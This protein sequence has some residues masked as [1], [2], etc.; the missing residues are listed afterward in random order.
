MNRSSFLFL[1]VLSP[2]FGFTQSANVPLNR[3][4][5]HLLER[6][7]ILNGHFSDQFHSEVKPYQRQRVG[8]FIDSLYDHS[9]LL[10]LSERDRFNL[11]YLANDSWEWTGSDSS[12]SQK[13]LLRYFYKKKPDLLHV[14]VPDFDLHLNPVI[15]FSGGKEQGSDITT[16]RNTRGLELRGAISR[17]LGFY[18][19]M[20]TTQAVN[21][22]YVRD[23]IQSNGVVPGEGFWKKF[24]DNGVDY[25]TAR[26]YIN[27]EVVKKYV[28]AEFGFDQTFIGSGH[29]SVIL[30]DF[31]PGYTYLKFNTKIW[32][33]NYTN[34][35]AQAFADQKYSATGSLDGTFPK[36]FLASHHLS[37]D[38]SRRLNIGVFES[39]VI[40]DSTE[41]FNAA[42][43]NPIIFY[44][45]LEHQGGSSENAM[46]GMDFKWIIGHSLSLYGQL[47]LDEFLLDEIKSGEGWWANKFGGQ[48]GGKY[49]N[50]AAIPN[51]DLQLEYNFAR[52]YLHAHEDIYTNYAHYRQPLGHTL[53]GN[54]TELVGIIRYQP[55]NR[56]F[57]TGQINIANYGDDT[58][59]SNWG[60][61]VMK[62]YNTREMEY[63]NKIGQGVATKLL[64]GQLMLSY[65]WKHN[66]FFDVSGIYRTLDSAQDANDTNTRYLKAA[67]RWNIARKIHDF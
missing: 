15:Y 21:P 51:L 31:S 55:L 30:S 27:F 45:A 1:L 66:L 56:L 61:N 11:V 18:S 60:K 14:E 50:V 9:D 8:A 43:L 41:R 17:R 67:M 40:G 6:Y 53:G 37:I 28:T 33:L 49:I 22:G 7:E 20:S 4:Y 35:F 63:G 13:P 65:M 47:V 5:Y 34:I 23:Y 19:F 24:K 44:R 62:S 36:K 57:V 25:F 10:K 58:P 3:D 38:I 52:P 2:V 59:D 42:Y 64:F 29:R 12:D 46:V 54:F 39:V 16:Y 26:G 32:K 48:M